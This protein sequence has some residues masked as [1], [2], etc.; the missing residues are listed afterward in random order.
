M[1]YP[2]LAFDVNCLRLSHNPRKVVKAL[3]RLISYL[4]CLRSDILVL[5]NISLIL[6]KH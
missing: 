4:K 2:T 6:M 3:G 1:S 5:E